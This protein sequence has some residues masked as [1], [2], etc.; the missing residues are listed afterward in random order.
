[1]ADHENKEIIEYFNSLVYGLKKE[2]FRQRA[3]G[4]TFRT[5]FI[6]MDFLSKVLEEELKKIN[7]VKDDKEKLEAVFKNIADKLIKLGIIKEMHVE[8]PP[9]Q[10]ITLG[11]VD[12]TGTVLRVRVKGC[13][14]YKI[15]RKLVDDKVPP[16]VLCPIVNLFMK[17]GEILLGTSESVSAIVKDDK[18]ECELEIAAFV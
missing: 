14:H 13:I 15:D 2:F 9:I 17:V 18:E 3:Y 8:M 1:M 7:E 4:S 5:A 16:I 6:G 10:K 12:V 11:F